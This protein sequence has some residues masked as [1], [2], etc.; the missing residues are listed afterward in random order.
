MEE[1]L[2]NGL[3]MIPASGDSALYAKVQQSV[4]IGITDSYIDDSLN[5]RNEGFITLTNA[6]LKKFEL[7]DRNFDLLDFYR[8]HIKTLPNGIF[9]LSQQYYTRNLK[10][11]EP[12]ATFEECHCHHTLFSWLSNMRPD[13]VCVAIKA[14]QVIQ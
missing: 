9:N 2:I 10:Y 6:T 3:K 12:N 11:L 5:G 8:S 1:H 13:I 14:F 4:V 7:K